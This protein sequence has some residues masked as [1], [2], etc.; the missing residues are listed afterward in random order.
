MRGGEGV[1]GCNLY[2][3]GWFNILST[4]MSNCVC[5]VFSCNEVENRPHPS[6]LTPHPILICICC[7]VSFRKKSAVETSTTR[8]GDCHRGGGSAN[9][10]LINTAIHVTRVS[11][12]A[13]ALGPHPTVHTIFCGK[14]ENISVSHGRPSS[15]R[16]RRP[17]HRKNKR[18]H[19]VATHSKRL[20]RERETPSN[21]RRARVC[22]RRR[23]CRQLHKDWPLKKT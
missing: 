16:R 20:S 10:M 23:R 12:G 13:V 17:T 21:L 15:A 5:D 19:S 7:H 9:P 4:H 6:P 18:N 1:R 14:V 8:R 22:G 3:L 2:F 11:L